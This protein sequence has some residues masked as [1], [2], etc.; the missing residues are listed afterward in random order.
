M[1]GE[2]NVSGGVHVSSNTSMEPRRT[3]VVEVEVHVVDSTINAGLQIE[4]IEGED[5][6]TGDTVE[7]TAGAGMGSRY[8][9]IRVNDS[10][11]YFDAAKLLND[12]AELILTDEPD[13]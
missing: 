6:N 13:R 10:V 3:V 8:G 4:W 7:I 5:P 12:A 2:L 11:A 9:T 1:S